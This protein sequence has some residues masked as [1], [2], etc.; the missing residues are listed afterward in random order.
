M[1]WRLLWNL[2]RTERFKQSRS[3]KRVFCDMIHIM[4]YIFC[5]LWKLNITFKNVVYR[6]M[7]HGR[8]IVATLWL[9]RTDV[10]RTSYVESHHNAVYFRTYLRFVSW[11][12]GRCPRSLT[13]CIFLI[14]GSDD[15][16]KRH[17]GGAS[18]WFIC[19]G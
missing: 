17:M 6:G 15:G 9:Q 14:C 4:I 8:C 2:I 11:D 13:H 19:T 1:I 10:T 7:P 5:D 12:L 3:C 16:R 18:F